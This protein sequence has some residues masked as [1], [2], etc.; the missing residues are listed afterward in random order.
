MDNEGIA[1][2]IGAFFIFFLIIMLFV[3]AISV[4]LI[5]AKWKLYEK[6]GEPGW[7]AIVP[8]YNTLQL[9]KIATGEFHLGIVWLILMG[10]NSL[11]TTIQNAAN[12]IAN[13][14]DGAMGFIAVIGLPFSLVGVVA[15]L[16]AAVLGGYL[17]YMFTKSFGQS[18]TMCIL[19]IFF[20]PIIFLIM[21]FKSD[22]Q[23]VGPQGNLRLW[24]KK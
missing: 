2:I 5:I 24:K 6:A 16:G 18:D 21:A 10:V 11:G 17:N 9:A 4:V 13:T 14:S 1:A 22:V 19:S 23:Y 7:S 8:I 15:A 3:L 12:M 20:A